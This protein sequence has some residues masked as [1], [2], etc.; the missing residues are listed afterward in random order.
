[1]ALLLKL[2]D[3]VLEAIGFMAALLL[4]FVALGIT[5]EILVRG[6][7]L[8]SLPW[9]IEIVEYALVAVTFLGAPWVLKHSAHVRVDI[10]VD[11]IPPKYRRGA[12]LAA[13]I[14]GICVCGVIFYYGL[15]STIELYNLDT[16]IFR[17]LTVKEWWLFALVPISF[18]AMFLEFVRRIL[19]GD[20]AK[21]DASDLPEAG[22]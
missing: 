16:K 8:G 3:F 20:Q 4:G 17:I 19:R 9:M 5:A 18:A 15:K 22:L 1:M 13:N 21:D 10:I 2:F 12:D 11:N 7:D 6:F 14:L